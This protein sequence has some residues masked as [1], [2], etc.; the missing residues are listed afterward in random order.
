M[1]ATSHD[2]ANASFWKTFDKIAAIREA[3]PRDQVQFRAPGALFYG[4]RFVTASPAT[5][6]FRL[7]GAQQPVDATYATGTSALACGTRGV[8]VITLDNKLQPIST[9]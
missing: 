2:D 8:L 4:Y 7:H 9:C 3:H 1:T 6:L 5:D